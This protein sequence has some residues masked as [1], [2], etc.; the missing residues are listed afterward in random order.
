MPY[1]INRPLR[2]KVYPYELFTYRIP[3]Y[4]DP[5]SLTKPKL[6]I[7]YSANDNE[8]P[9]FIKKDGFNLIIAPTIL[10]QGYHEINYYL[11]DSDG[12]T[13]KVT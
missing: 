13:T 5:D 8:L 9:F 10:N 6:K 11:T 7:T 12:D 4:T 1:F 3:T 2:L